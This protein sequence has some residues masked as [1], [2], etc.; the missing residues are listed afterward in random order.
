MASKL[1]SLDDLE[2]DL[3]IDFGEI[4]AKWDAAAA[5]ITTVEIGLEKSDIHVDDLALLWI[6]V[7]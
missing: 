1:E 6:P 5:D 2:D 7:S 4:S 3:A